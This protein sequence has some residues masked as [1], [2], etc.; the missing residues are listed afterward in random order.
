MKNTFNTLKAIALFSILFTTIIACDED[1]ANIDSDIQ[2]VKNFEGSSRTF[3]VL[4][5]TK[6]VTPFTAS[7]AEDMVGVR[8]DALPY[9]FF[10][11]YK[12][13]NNSEY[14]TTTASILTQI[15]P[16]EFDKDFGTDPVIKSVKLQI[17]YYSTLISTND[18]GE[19]TYE[20]DSVYGDLTKP[21]KLSIYRS[22]YLLRD[23]DPD[24]NF[25]E[26]QVYYSNQKN[27]FETQETELLYQK[28]N[29]QPSPS[30]I[31]ILGT[32]IDPDTGNPEVTER[33][34][35]SLYV[36]L[37]EIQDLDYW[38]NLTIDNEGTS[39]LSSANNFSNFFRGIFI[40]IEPEDGSDEG[41][42]VALNMTSDDARIIIDYDNNEDTTTDQDSDLT[43]YQ[44]AFSGI[45]VNTIENI[46]TISNDLNG[47]PSTGDENLYLKGFDGYMSVIELF[48]DEEEE[49]KAKKDSWLIN[50]ANLIFNVNENLV[51]GDEPTR[52]MLFD[53]KNNAPI[54]DYFLD[55][56][57]NSTSPDESKIQYAE[58]L[59]DGRY[60]FRLTNHIN[61]ILQRDST[62]VKLGLYVSAN[63]NLTQNSK[64][65]NTEVDEDDETQLTLI[66]TGSVIQPK[67]T[68]LH[69]NLSSTVDKRPVFEIFYTEPEND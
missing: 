14:G 55:G 61:N 32:E 63:V 11:V 49:F 65:Q 54:V 13:P 18:D 9:N 47:N 35:P 20:L 22:N 7:G 1:F 17:P 33:L 26:A 3:P 2:G 41:S 39:I 4:A 64:I 60:K 30:E 8:T 44:F 48:G 37:T 25:E 66:P 5:Y 24:T 31:E 6:S 68:I 59:S 10:G 40:K 43:T 57:T 62:N 67:A 27:L 19:N 51:A 53:L 16:T 34:V 23:L 58:A 28:N 45:R 56:T 36:D 29:F 50:E 21:F 52:I 12:D 15:I 38:K 46:N 69:G 42:L